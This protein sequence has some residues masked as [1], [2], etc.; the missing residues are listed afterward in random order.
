MDA[1]ERGELRATNRDKRKRKRMKMDGAG[2]RDLERVRAER[3]IAL[4][5]G[6]K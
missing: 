4:L 2:V 3:A 6:K 1:V 5:R